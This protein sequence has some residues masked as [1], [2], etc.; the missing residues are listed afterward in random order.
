MTRPRRRRFSALEPGEYRA[1][2]S[3]EWQIIGD[4]PPVDQPPSSSPAG[5]ETAT[6]NGNPTV[7]APARESVEQKTALPATPVP[8]F[9]ALRSPRPFSKGHSSSRLVLLS[10]VGVASGLLGGYLLSRPSKETAHLATLSYGE[11]D[12]PPLTAT[13]ES[14]LNAA[15]AARRAYKLAEAE[16]LFT[17]LKQKYPYWA[18]MEIEIGRTQLYEHKSKEAAVS[19]KAAAERESTA[20]QA[21]FLLGVLYK[22]QKS[23]PEAEW[24]FAKATALDPTQPSYYYFW[25]ECLREEGKLEAAADKF[26]STLLHNEYETDNGLYRLKLWLTEIEADHEGR[27]GTAAEIDN[28]LAQPHPP[29]EAFIAAAAREIKANDIRAAVLHLFRA[30]RRSDPT[31]FLYMMNDPFF[32]QARSRPELTKL[33][34]EASPDTEN[35]SARTAPAQNADSPA[36][37]N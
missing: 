27:D 31:V 32:V 20:A 25:G 4:P 18:A 29:V 1:Q 22:A 2:E 23:Y 7:P 3:V 33:W 9:R 28:A 11:T 16:Q 30:Q 6:G 36:K 17:A 26:R 12:A 35:E 5:D 10:L 21:H 19:L 14:D 34:R 15:Y 8:E 13:D 24:N 37:S